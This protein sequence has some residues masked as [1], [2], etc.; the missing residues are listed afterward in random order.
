MKMDTSDSEI[1]AINENLNTTQNVNDNHIN[2]KVGRPSDRFW[3]YFTETAEPYKLLSSTCKHCGN[4]VNYHKKLEQ[5]KTHLL[6]CPPFIRLNDH[7]SLLGL[8]G[9]I[10]NEV[11][12]VGV[13]LHHRHHH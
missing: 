8:I 2:K 9:S 11:K 5:A 7:Q 1:S 13:I 6:K 10:T 12:S 3:D 4:V